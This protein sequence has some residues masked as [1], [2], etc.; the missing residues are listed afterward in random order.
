LEL[1]V[2]DVFRFMLGEIIFQST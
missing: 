1:L 2:N